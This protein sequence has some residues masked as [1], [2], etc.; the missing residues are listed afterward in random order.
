MGRAASGHTEGI[1][2][3]CRPVFRVA[4]K[5]AVLENGIAQVA[6]RIVDLDEELSSGDRVTAEVTTNKA[7][8]NAG[9]DQLTV[10]GGAKNG[11]KT[12][13]AGLEI[14]L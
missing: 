12:N 5:H 9:H 6:A 7:V 1:I 10:G 14:V 8:A 13:G 2:D 3:S 11:I 4:E